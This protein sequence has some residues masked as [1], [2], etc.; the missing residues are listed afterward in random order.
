MWLGTGPW[1]INTNSGVTSFS[2]N[3]FANNL[4]L[5]S[6]GTT[7]NLINT[8]GNIAFSHNL[9][10]QGGAIINAA[11]ASGATVATGASGSN[12][13]TMGNNFMLG[14]FI[15]YNGPISSSLHTI[16]GNS[17]QGTLTF[18]L[19]SGSKQY[20]V[21]QNIVNG[22][23]T[24]ND[25]IVFS[26]TLGSTNTF[27]GNN[28]NGTTTINNRASAS[29]AISTNNINS[30][31][32]NNDFD[33]SS[34]AS[35]FNR[36]LTISGNALFGALQNNLYASGAVGAVSQS[37]AFS[38]NLFA[39][40]FLSASIVANGTEGNMYGT[41][42]AGNDLHIAGTSRRDASSQNG[43]GATIGSAFFGRYNKTGQGFNTTAEVI[44]A[45]GTGTS[46]S[47]GVVRKTGFLIDSGSNTFIEGTLN[48]S[49]STT[50]TGSL[51]LSSSNAVELQVIGNSEF[52]GSVNGNVVSM[53]VTSNTASMDFNI[54]NYFE[55]TASV[56]PIRVE[57]T[58][59]KG[60]TTKT[61]ALNGVTSSTIVWSS[62]VLQPSGSAYTASVSGS[63]DILSFVSFNT[64]LVN[65][66]STLK[67]I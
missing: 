33:A 31:N 29:L 9:A 16:N 63:N 19:Q 12:S 46:G 55:L 6:S 13:L 2:Q 60:G 32:I 39:G 7:L 41:I 49:G 47:T 65:V 53:S 61:L 67:M 1:T 50:M 27:T 54:G 59:L 23:L 35:A 40:Q 10:V 58:N 25:N 45:V 66:V 26:P 56:S 44:L 24:L 3:T 52:T 34:V 62:N 48:V 18:N 5:G 64:S 15:T 51:I 43:A 20:T 38:N 17:V 14:G 11:S 21:N 42:G 36:S 4:F 37:K 22:T 8:T 28:I 57:V 30:W